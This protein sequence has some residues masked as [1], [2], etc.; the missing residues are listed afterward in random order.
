VV[1]NQS[2]FV[3]LTADLNWK[4]KEKGSNILTMMGQKLF[5]K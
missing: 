5:V 1:D 2:V 4:L 3:K